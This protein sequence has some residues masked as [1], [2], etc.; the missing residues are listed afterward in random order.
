MR[1]TENS[2]SDLESQTNVVPTSL[3]SAFEMF[4]SEDLSGV[5]PGQVNQE[6]FISMEQYSADEEHAI[7]QRPLQ[8]A[9]DGAFEHTR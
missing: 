4:V 1:I 8:Q 3:V 7:S 6:D 5:C 2:E 9:D